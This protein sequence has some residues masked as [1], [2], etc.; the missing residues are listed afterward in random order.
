M[1]SRP[2]G[3]PGTPR[4][5]LARRTLT[6]EKVLQAAI[7]LVDTE[8]LESLS[9]RRLASAVGVQAMSLYNHVT[10][11]DDLLDGI[12]ELVAGQ[13]APPDPA[14]G[15]RESMRERTLSARAVL[16]R[17]PWAATLMEARGNAG[18]ARLDHSE[19]LVATFRLAGFSLELT[20]RA[21]L[22]LDSHLYGFL[23]Q[24]QAWPTA[25][26]SAVAAIVESM[27][28]AMPPERYPYL[29]ELLRT[30]VV[31]VGP[32]DAGAFAFGLDLI[33]DGLDRARDAEAAGELHRTREAGRNP[34]GV[35]GRG[36][37]PG[38]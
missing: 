20:H 2:V 12:T 31:H 7:E 3:G 27:S 25:D 5:G 29:S 21:L 16:Q 36:D 37:A 33:L 18:P 23:L 26:P 35:A 11:K 14:A 34:V 13:I 17:H 10:D 38:R 6:R 15:W 1:G 19:A 24:E 32:A 9:M 30:R 28:G 22:T 4:G 8:G